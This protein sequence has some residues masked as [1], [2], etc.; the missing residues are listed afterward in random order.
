MLK[1]LEDLNT[2]LSIRL[3]LH[4]YDNI[5]PPF[6]DYVIKSGR[7]TFKVAGE[8]ELDLTIADEDPETQF[9]FIDFRFLF[10]PSLEEIPY[11]LRFH[12]ENRVNSVLLAEG[13]PGCYRVLHE[14]VLTHKISEF[15]RQ[16]VALARGKW[17]D[18]LKVEALNRSLS[19]Q[20]WLDR[21]TKIGPKSWII[22]G[23]HS[24]RRKDG[25][26][27]PKRTSHLFLRW[28]REGKEVKDV[29]IPFDSIDISTESLL[30]TVIAKHID[31][32]MSAT[33]QQLETRPLF[34]EG[35]ASLSLT[36]SPDEPSES[37]LKVQLTRQEHVL[38]TIEPITGRFIFS[39]ASMTNSKMEAHFNR[40]SKDPTK[41]ASGYIETLRYE[42][43]DQEITSHALSVG[44]IRFTMPGISH[45]VIKARFPKGTARLLW[46]RKY[47][48]KKDWYMVVSISMSG[49][50][51]WLAE[52]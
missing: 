6:R 44:W 11:A 21:Y 45:E 46:F 52:T 13:L 49:E 30:K 4:E 23:V 2:L 26:Q 5:P 18:G 37:S 35:D 19:I 14:M 24:G 42:T 50:Q 15:R 25:R 1:E 12:I 8:F 41:E 20:Y 38:I 47:S 32:I 16:A 7:V 31:H 9:W 17:I 29:E 40:T 36:A 10:S 43:V 27:D 22:L 34:S 33:H 48:W 39:P 28:F 3:N 51:W